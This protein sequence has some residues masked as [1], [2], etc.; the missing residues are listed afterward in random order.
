MS[1][2]QA[3]GQFVRCALA[4]VAAGALA[5]CS[6][7]PAMGDKTKTGDASFEDLSELFVS[8]AVVEYNAFQFKPLIKWISVSEA[9]RSLS[10]LRPSSVIR[11][12]S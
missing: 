12:A 10:T 6:S 5:A 4:L 2:M 8:S 11:K 9:S 7:G 3:A 1:T